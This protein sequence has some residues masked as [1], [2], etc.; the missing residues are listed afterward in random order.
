MVRIH[1][2]LP[3]D[4]L[5][6][7][8]VWPINSHCFHIKGDGRQLHF[9]RDLTTECSEDDEQGAYNHRNETQA[10]QGLVGLYILIE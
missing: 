10:G 8:R 7:V 9:P 1:A 2:P 6:F 5:F 3:G 4:D